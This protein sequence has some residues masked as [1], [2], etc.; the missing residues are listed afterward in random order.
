MPSILPRTPRRTPAQANGDAAQSLVASV[1]KTWSWTADQV[2]SDFG[3]DLECNIYADNERTSFYFRVQVKA[4]AKHKLDRRRDHTSIKISVRASTCRQWLREFFPVILV[5]HD[6]ASDRIH[7]CDP[8]SLLRANPEWL[9]NSRITFPVRTSNDFRTSKQQISKLVEAFYAGLLRVDDATFR[10]EIIPVLMPRYRSEPWPHEF[11]K[12]TSNRQGLKVEQIHLESEN[13]P[14]WL[15]AVRVFR[16]DAIAAIRISARSRGIESFLRKV[17]RYIATSASSPGEGEWFAFV[18]CPVRLENRTTGVAQ[19]SI[20]S[21]TITDYRAE[22]LIGSAL[23]DDALYSF[24]YLADHRH[25]IGRKAQSW[26]GNFQVDPV[27]DIAVDFISAK[28]AG[29]GERAKVALFTQNIRAQLLPWVCPKKSLTELQ[30]LLSAAEL[31][32]NEIPDVKCNGDEIAGAISTPF[33]SPRGTFN[34]A[35]SWHE[36][37]HGIIESR[38][39]E[40]QL[41]GQLPGRLGHGD[42]WLILEKL[43]SHQFEPPT[44]EVMILSNDWRPGLPLNHSKRRIVI[45]RFDASRRP[46]RQIELNASRALARLVTKFGSVEDVDV[47]PLFST[48]GAPVARMSITMRPSLHLSAL[49]FYEEVKPFVVSFLNSQFP[50]APSEGNRTYSTLGLQG[51]LYFEE[52]AKYIPFRYLRSLDGS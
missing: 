11:L 40:A 31:V 43:F 28:D 41:F 48:T 19:K 13:L 18:I 45:A 47:S 25:V 49:A 50:M 29:P 32:F 34:M 10:C 9:A 37:E 27:S 24:P 44:E 3:E 14:G 42:T 20:L 2:V 5:V 36:L 4:T 30:R 38:L 39:G 15:S 51:E 33:T 22:S 8:V 52:D 26:I 21:N 17:R 12:Q 35:M 6:L 23:V 1:I 7:W 16:P 46:A